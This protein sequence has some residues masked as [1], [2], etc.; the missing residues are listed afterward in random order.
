MKAVS[1][2]FFGGDCV[3]AMKFYESVFGGKLEVMTYGD[4]PGDDL[5]PNVD[6]TKVMHAAL[7]MQDGAEIYASDDEGGAP[8]GG[9]RGFAVALN[10]KSADDAKTLYDKLVEGGKIDMPLTATFWSPAFAMFTDR[11][12]TPWIIS[13]DPA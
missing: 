1:Y 4:Q 7:T 6:R 9:M 8:Y 11:F 12:G 3:E 10:P 5:P 13:A 2:L